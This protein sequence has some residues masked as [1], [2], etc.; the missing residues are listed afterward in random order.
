MPRWPFSLSPGDRSVKKLVG[1]RR[2]ISNLLLLMG[3]PSRPPAAG[4]NGHIQK[5]PDPES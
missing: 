4:R 5:L 2:E 1:S 3:L